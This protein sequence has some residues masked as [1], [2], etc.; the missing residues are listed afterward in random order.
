[1]DIIDFALV[2]WTDVGVYVA[3]VLVA[4]LIANLINK[5]LGDTV[6]GAAILTAI[7]FSGAYL[8][9]NYYPH[10]IDVGQTKVVSSEVNPASAAEPAA[11]EPVAAPA[12]V[13]ADAPETAPEAS[14]EPAENAP[15][16]EAE[17]ADNSAEIVPAPAEQ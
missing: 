8:G 11:P 9:W 12:S 13:P 16:E 6:V 14:S 5:A 7:I 1:M 17:P 2:N 15:A 10:G 4:S 3:L